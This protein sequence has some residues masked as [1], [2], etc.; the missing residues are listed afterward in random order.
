[1]SL[2]LAAFFWISHG[3]HP[4][5]PSINL[6]RPVAA[7]VAE[8]KLSPKISGCEVGFSGVVGGW[9]LDGFNFKSFFVGIF[10]ST[11][12]GDMIQFGE[13]FLP[14]D[15]SGGWLSMKA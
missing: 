8:V 4:L 2:D 15:P 6:H 5:D 12:V 3:I 14:L 10:N 7:E 11:S 1:M 9:L 13:F